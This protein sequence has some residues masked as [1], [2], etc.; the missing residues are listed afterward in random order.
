[1]YSLPLMDPDGPRRGVVMAEPPGLRTRGSLS[2]LRG[3]LA[4]H[5]RMNQRIKLRLPGLTSLFVAACLVVGTVW[6]QTPPAVIASAAS[7]APSGPVVLGAADVAPAL[8]RGGYVIYF[9]HTAT[10]FSKDDAASTGYGDCANQRLLSPAGRRV[11]TETG[12]QISALKLPVT[13]VLASPMCRTMDTAQRLFGRATPQPDLREGE[14]GGI[15]SGGDY[16]GLKRLLA[17]PVALGGNRW[18]VGH[19]SPFRAIAGAP[20]LAEGEAAVIRPEGM[21]WTVV[22]RLLPG[23]WAGLK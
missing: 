14:A 12:R 16:P 6:S 21:G 8:R 9:R 11:A 5:W 2:E 4:V 13:E 19:G 10:D 3:F 7:S 18:L 1:M 17:A 23:D 22:A 20:H 15:G